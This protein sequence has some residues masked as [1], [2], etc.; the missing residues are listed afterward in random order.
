MKYSKQIFLSLLFSLSIV[1]HSFGQLVTSLI[2]TTFNGYEIDT[3]GGTKQ[4]YYGVAPSN[5]A[6]QSVTW[7]II[8][9]LGI[10]SINPSTGLVTAIAN[11]TVIAKCV[12]NDGS[13]IFDT[14][15]LTISNQTIDGICKIMDEDFESTP[16]S[17]RWIGDVNKFTFSSVNPGSGNYS[18]ESSNTDVNSSGTLNTN[19]G[20]R[21]YFSA[22]NPTYISYQIKTN[23]VTSP[24]GTISIGNTDLSYLGNLYYVN[25]YQS[26]LRIIGSNTI[27]YPANNNAWYQIE[28]VNIDWVNHR[29]DL[30]VNGQLVMQ[31]FG[32]RYPISNVTHVALSHTNPNTS[33][34]C[35]FDNIIVAPTT[36]M[37]NSVIQ[38][39]SLLTS[40]NSTASYQWIDCNLGS[41]VVGETNQSFTP[42]VNGSYSVE[43]TEG[44]C[45][46]TSICYSVLN[47]G[48]I[49]EDNK[50][51]A[52]YP[53]PTNGLF[54]INLTNTKGSVDYTITTL[55][56]RIVKR[57]SNANTSSIEVD[58]THESQGIYLLR[59]NEKNS[60]KVYKVVKQ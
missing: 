21:Y 54:T 29:S 15:T 27:N 32:F 53:N 57:V 49:E 56:G 11:G 3:P 26:Y 47:V 58:L 36:S 1:N 39:G 14:Q 18:I 48:V 60:N 23:T 52:V 20:M 16:L 50:Q 8:N 41:Y 51:I 31:N 10:A 30:Y 33:V 44:N 7:S 42:S 45:V 40:N 35:N 5:A 4:L 55:E 38:S 59:I 13:G 2:I 9:T 19:E 22:S 6:D 28:H 37:D 12:A 24:S 43:I 25:F 17:D 34:V 46:D